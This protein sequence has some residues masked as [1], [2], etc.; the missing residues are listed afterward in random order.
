MIQQVN[1]Y[2][3]AFKKQIQ[4]FSA[5]AMLIMIGVLVAILLGLT[6]F[7]MKQVSDHEQ[8]VQQKQ[9]QKEQLNQQLE[10]AKVKLKPREKNQL[11]VQQL[12]DKR[13]AF[14]DIKKIKVMLDNVLDKSENS[15][16]GYFEGLAKSNVNGLWLTQIRVGDAG[17][18]MTLSGKTASGEKVPGLLLKLENQPAFTD[19]SFQTVQIQENPENNVLNFTLETAPKADSEQQ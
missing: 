4:L 5:Q 2:Q 8:V 11:L 3:P 9:Q 13:L 7:T 10:Q 15:F 12:R 17:K 16:S 18:A 19:A 6:L 14:S 1:F